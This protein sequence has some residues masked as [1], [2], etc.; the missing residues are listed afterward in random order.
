MSDHTLGAALGARPFS[1]RHI[2]PDDQQVTE[3][4]KTL[5]VSSLDALM[6]DA[7]PDRIRSAALRLPP[8][9]SERSTAAELREIEGS[10]A[11]LPSERTAD[12][13]ADV[14]SDELAA[15]RKARLT[16]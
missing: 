15:R 12:A 11:D 1:E 6:D 4:L 2:G 7:V 3:M 14:A 13:E 16:G 9:A 10:L 5:G 8:A